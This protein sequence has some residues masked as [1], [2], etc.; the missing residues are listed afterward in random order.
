VETVHVGAQRV[1][2]HE[3]VAGVVHDAGR[4][5]SIAEGVQLL[6]LVQIAR[7]SGLQ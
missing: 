4:G 2:Q 1:G 6:A 7:A 5:V 3:G